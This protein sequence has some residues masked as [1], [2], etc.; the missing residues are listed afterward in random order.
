[1]KNLIKEI[2]TVTALVSLTACALQIKDFNGQSTYAPIV[3]G[4]T[5]Q[6]TKKENYDNLPKEFRVEGLDDLKIYEENIE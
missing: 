4:L 1:M 6:S 3:K 5:G 2:V